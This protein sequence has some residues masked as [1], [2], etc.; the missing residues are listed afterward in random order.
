MWAYDRCKLNDP[1]YMD[2]STLIDEE[3]R[4]RYINLY[5]VNKNVNTCGHI[6]PLLGSSDTKIACKVHKAK[7]RGNENF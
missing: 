6:C 5:N 1:K 4:Q 3:L 2:C 7:S